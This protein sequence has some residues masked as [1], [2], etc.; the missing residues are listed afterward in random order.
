M[1]RGESLISRWGGLSLVAAKFVPGVSVVAPP[2]AGALGM[3]VPRFIGYDTGAA[4]IWT[5]VFLGLGWVFRDQIQEVL[6]MLAQAPLVPVSIRGGREVLPKG[7]LR[8]RPGVM[9]VVVG[10][11]IPAPE[12]SGASIDAL[13]ARVRAALLAGLEGGSE[14]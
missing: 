6:A 12:G 1:R 4:L 2:M 9:D 11:P 13:V 5:G 14:G 3:S 7:S 10:E 8:I